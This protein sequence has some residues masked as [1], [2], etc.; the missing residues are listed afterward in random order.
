MDEKTFN[1]GLKLLKRFLKEKGLYQQIFVNYL[2]KNNRPVID[3]FNEF[4]SKKFSDIDDWRLLFR[5]VNLMVG[6]NNKDL[7]DYLEWETIIADNKIHNEWAEY[8]GKYN[9]NK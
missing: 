6:N 3:L 8:Y 7:F 1:E 4:N 5:R 2:F 9:K